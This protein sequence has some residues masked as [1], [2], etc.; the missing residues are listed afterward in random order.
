M[1]NYLKFI[2]DEIK[3]NLNVEKIK[4]IDN[5]LKHREHR[6][7]DINKY[8]LYLEIESNYLKSLDKLTAQRSILNILK[9]EMKSK[10]HALEIKIK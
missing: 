1:N 6:F 8:H 9:K 3:K 2:E 5:T 10:I 7:F 4:V